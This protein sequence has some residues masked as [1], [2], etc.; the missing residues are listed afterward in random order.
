MHEPCLNCASVS[1]IKKYYIKHT[2]HHIVAC[3]TC[4]LVQVNPRKRLLNIVD[5]ETSSVRDSKL[6]QLHELMVKDTG[7][8]LKE[9]MEKENK[10]RRKHFK[11]R[12]DGIKQYKNSGKL[13]DVGCAQGAFLSACSDTNFQLYG[14]EPSK[15]TYIEALKN[16]SH[17]TFYNGTLLEARFL[18]DYFDV[19]TLINTLEHLLNP[20]EALV[21]IS[22][23]LRSGGLLMIETPNMGNWIANVSGRRWVQLQFPDHVTFF[24]KSILTQIL[25]ELGFE[26]QQV[27]SGNKILSVRLFLFYLGRY[28]KILSKDLLKICEKVGFADKIISFP[29][30]DEMVLFATKR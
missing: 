3:R 21:E 14:V 1:F 12:I 20:K 29:Q 16:A 8:S 13:L 6:K 11:T 4:G 15:Y 19:I 17:G 23:I 25:Q 26:I 7:L 5:Y 2:G 22:R 30:W 24:S 18:D 10:I 9:I 27:K 28:V